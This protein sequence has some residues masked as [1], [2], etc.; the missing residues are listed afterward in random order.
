MARFVRIMVIVVLAAF[1]PALIVLWRQNPLPSTVVTTPSADPSPITDK[2]IGRSALSHG[3]P[4]PAPLVTSQVVAEPNALEL[5]QAVL[6]WP[7]GTDE[8]IASVSG[9]RT[10]EPVNVII[11]KRD[12]RRLPDNQKEDWY[13][14]RFADGTTAWVKR[15]S[16][17]VSTARNE[18]STKER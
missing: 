10:R 8:R 11:A 6:L 18:R 17:S 4:A 15:Q 16:L 3:G 7:D 2:M 5:G 13:E 14:V 9:P 1:V 12:T